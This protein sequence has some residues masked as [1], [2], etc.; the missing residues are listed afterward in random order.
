MLRRA[1]V[2]ASSRTLRLLC[3]L[4]VTSFL[5][6]LAGCGRH[7]ARDTSS[8]I[9]L[10]E[11]NPTN[12]DPRYAT[13][14]QSQRIDSLLFSSLLERDD[15]MNFHGDLAESWSTP[16]PLTYIFH[17]RAGVHFH[18]G[19]P[20]TAV[21]VKYTFDSILDPVTHSPKRGAFRMIA[22]ID[23]PDAATVVFH[24][25]A[26]YA[27]FL[28]NL[29]RPAVGIIPQGAGADFSRH[30]VGS[31]PFRFVSQSQDEDAVIARNPDY[32]R[33][34]PQIAGGSTADRRGPA[35]AMAPGRR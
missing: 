24:L 12:L 2:S 25:T 10:I 33:G 7:T 13:D 27:S 22:S 15:K 8:L 17:L 1:S 28:W 18:D 31:G 20:L 21:D 19:R 6:L 9:F 3:A 32:L 16:A 34:A 23:A 11:S 26:P 35:S 5:F 29:T 4:C 14:G 30:P